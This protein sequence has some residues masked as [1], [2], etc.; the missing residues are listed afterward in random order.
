MAA[1]SPFTDDE[2]VR[3][4]LA[5]MTEMDNEDYME[6]RFVI[7]NGDS[8]MPRASGIGG[9][10]A[11]TMYRINGTEPT[12]LRRAEYN[13]S[14][15]MGYAGQE[16]KAEIMRRMGYTVRTVHVPLRSDVMTGHIDGTVC[17]LDMGDE[18]V[19]WDSKLRNLFGFRKL[20]VEGLPKGDPEMYLQMQWYMGELGLKWA[21]VTI[22]PHDYSSMRN[23]VTRYKLPVFNA[24]VHRIIIPFDQKAYEL[25]CERAR[26]LLAAKEL[27]LMVAREF[28]PG[29]PADA[30]FPCGFCPFMSRCL[31]DDFERSV[32][33]VVEVPPIPAEWLVAA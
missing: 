1:F 14:A 25:A 30:R 31:A 9:C 32:A 28:N 10:A 19:L 17:G 29:K 6:Y 2:F 18:P 33:G 5:A 22:A 21:L 24:I 4:W 27:G 16:F 15:W 7:E 8:G 12:D 3:R 13:W 11:R 23:E 20:V 26:V